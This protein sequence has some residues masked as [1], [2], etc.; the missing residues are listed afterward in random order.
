MTLE[1]KVLQMQST[2]PA[3]PRLGVPA[4]NW[5]NEA[6]HGVAQG[7]ATVFPQ[8]IG[9]A[10]T[11]DTDLM[12]RVADIISTEARAKYNDALT[13]P[14]PSGPEAL[15]TLP[16]ARPD[17]R[18]GRPTSISSGTRVGAAARKLTEKIL[19]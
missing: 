8:A 6:L 19:I 11:W 4:Y 12:H 2:A 14:A 10:A 15:M 17:L 18:T 13:R 7:R 1:E 9:L 3:I 16:A 5:W